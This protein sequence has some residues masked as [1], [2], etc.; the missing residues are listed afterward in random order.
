MRIGVLALQGDFAEHVAML[1][2]VGRYRGE[3]LD[4]CE[5]RT[6]EEL[7]AVDGLVIPGGESTTIGKLMGDFGLREPLRRRVEHGM[8]VFGTC[9]G[10]I[11]LAR[12]VDGLVHPLVGLMDISVQRNAFGR[13]QQSFE[14][15][16]P[17]PSLGDRPM[18]AI[19]IRAP[20]ITAVGAGVQVMAHLPDGGI[21]AARQAH[22]LAAS[23]HPEL[24]GDDRLH[25]YFAEIVLARK[26]QCDRRAEDQETRGDMEGRVEAVH[27]L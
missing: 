15:D 18:R 11:A 23:F 7:A 20:A 12:D 25:R 6:V 10:A 1:A 9:A 2:G 21:V 4:V 13:Q 3:P 26:E 14:A 16:V 17:I 22:L 19:F 5:V 24:T 27:E 8:P